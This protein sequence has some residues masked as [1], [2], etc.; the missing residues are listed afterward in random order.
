MSSSSE[1]TRRVLDLAKNMASY[2]HHSG[3][4][5][6]DGGHKQPEEA[7]EHPDC[8]AVREFEKYE[9]PST[10]AQQTGS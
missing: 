7:C 6:Y 8:V 3:Y 9:R 4:P 5:V 10:N 2:I 1:H